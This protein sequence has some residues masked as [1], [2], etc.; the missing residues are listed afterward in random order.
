MRAGETRNSLNACYLFWKQFLRNFLRKFSP[1]RTCLFFFLQIRKSVKVTD[2]RVL[3]YI[4]HCVSLSTQILCITWV[5]KQTQTPKSLNSIFL[6]F[7]YKL[8][9][10]STRIMVSFKNIIKVNKWLFLTNYNILC[11]YLKF[12]HYIYNWEWVLCLIQEAKT[13]AYSSTRFSVKS[14]LLSTEGLGWLQDSNVSIMSDSH[15]SSGNIE[16]A[17]SSGEDIHLASH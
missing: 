1:W 16:T 11:S 14:S 4:E 2:H 6:L 15:E 13:S 5:F 17:V 9:Q 12:S 8:G 7:S 10:T 3:T